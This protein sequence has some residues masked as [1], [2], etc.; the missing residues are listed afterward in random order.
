M[1]LAEKM[2]DISGSSSSASESE[3]T[4]L[5]LLRRAM[6]VYEYI[7]LHYMYSMLHKQCQLLKMS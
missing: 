7:G 1:D 3:S 5:E 2:V 4:I 6:V